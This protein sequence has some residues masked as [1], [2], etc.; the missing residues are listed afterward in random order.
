[1]KVVWQVAGGL[2][3]IGAAF[4]WTCTGR[5]DGGREP[6]G[7]SANR[8]GDVAQSFAPRRTPSGMASGPYHGMSWQIHY[9]ATAVEQAKVMCREIADLG[10]D[11]VMI[12]NP[13]YQEHAG[14]DSFKIDPVVTPSREQWLEIFRIAHDNGLRIILM[15]IILLSDPR[16]NEWRGV[17][18]PPNWDDWFEQYRKFILHFARIA[19]EG[20]VEVFMVGSE[21]VSTEKFTNRWHE[22][23][24]EARKEFS[25]K[26]SYSA[27]WDH[28]KVVEFWDELDLVGMTSYYKL[29]SEPRPSLHDLIKA[30][31]PL[32]KGLLKWQATVNKPLLFTEAGWCSQEGASIEPWNYYYKQEATPAGLE[33]QLNCYL[34][35]METWKYSDE[36]GKRLTPE[37]LGGVLWWEWNDTPGGK[38]DYNYTPRGKPAEKALRDWFAAARKRWPATSPAK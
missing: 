23:I 13:G 11:T 14:S 22:V 10:A 19:E 32:R 31:G 9:S 2:C 37:Q 17:I 38:N 12:S 30:W 24:R 25:G 21:L 6:S 15:P 36:P 4:W 35:F 29:S 18:S 16:G 34:A 1:M 3:V 8:G 28:Y 27:N 26:L 20:K 7:R 33:E 5:G